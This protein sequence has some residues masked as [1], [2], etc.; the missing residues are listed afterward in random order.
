MK[1]S[2]S[3]VE[4][5]SLL[6]LKLDSQQYQNYDFFE[7]RTTAD[8][9]LYKVDYVKVVE[10]REICECYSEPTSVLT[11]KEST[12]I[13]ISNFTL[14]ESDKNSLLSSELGGVVFDFWIKVNY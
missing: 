9:R 6:F 2:S 3:K 12:N 5:S 10:P 8:T 4:A 7:N 14:S 1:A 11:I 13:Q